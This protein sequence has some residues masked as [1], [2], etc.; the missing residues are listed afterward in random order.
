MWCG[1]GGGGG[2]AVQGKS[3]WGLISYLCDG[4]NIIMYGYIYMDGGGVM[5]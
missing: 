1:G 4:D 3:G 2:E 5:E